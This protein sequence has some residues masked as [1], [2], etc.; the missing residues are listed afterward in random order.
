MKKKWQS[1]DVGDLTGK[2]AVVTGAS[3]G[4]GVETARV[5]AAHGARVVMAVRNEA[6]GEQVRQALTRNEPSLKLEV[7]TLDLADLKSV[8]S[9]VAGVQKDF[10]Q[11]DILVNNAG[12]MIPP[13]GL[14]KDGF[15]TQMGTNHLGHFALTARLY[16]LLKKAD[17]AHIVNTSSI[18]HKQGK[19]NFDDLQW[20]NRKYDPWKAYGD[21]KLANL[22]FTYHFADLLK[23][24]GSNMVV[25]AAHPGWT[26]TNLIQDKAFMAV[27]ARLAVKVMGQHVDGGALPNLRAAVDPEVQAGDYIGPGGF[28]ELKGAP[29]KVKSNKRSHD[30]EAAAQLWQASEKLTG[31]KLGF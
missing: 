5:L 10:K 20:Q 23:Q 11:L 26:I 27:L 16:P 30:D 2:S 3:S 4:I 1:S 6:K 14:T 7:R 8:E 24:A 19:L 18:A 25:A 13:F 29:V 12:V 22:Y 9:F 31:L 15:E 17:A 28:Q 21:S